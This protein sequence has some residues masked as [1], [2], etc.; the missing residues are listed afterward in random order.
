MTSKADL[1]RAADVI[2]SSHGYVNVVIANSGVTGPSMAGL[3]PNSS[4]TAFRNHLW[5]W[6]P[7]EFNKSYEVNATAVFY[8]LVAFLE[9]LDEGNKR[10]N[11]DQK[12]QFIAISSLGAYN[13]V[14][15]SGYAYGSSKAAVTHMMKQLATALVPYGIRANVIAPGCKS[16]LPCLMYLQFSY[17]SYSSTLLS[18]PDII[19]DY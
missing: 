13:R 19:T 18:P 8:T 6:D 5:N 11:V 16:I 1:K 4:L 3:A 15:S 17:L 9:L 10:G 7:A 2:K 14:P 12:S